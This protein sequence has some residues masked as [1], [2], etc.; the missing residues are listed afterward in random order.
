MS[1][2]GPKHKSP[3]DV[4]TPR[5]SEVNPVMYIN[6]P[7]L[8]ASLLRAMRTGY[9]VVIYGDSGC[10]KSWLYKKVFSDNRVYW[11]TL[12]FSASENADDVD[13]QIL[14]LVASFQEWQEE[15]TQTET[16]TRFAPGGVGAGSKRRKVM[17]KVSTSPLSQLLHHIR[18][19]AGRK[20]AFLVLENI[21]HVLDKPEVLR[22]IQNMLL[23]LDDPAIASHSVRLCLVG[24][25]AE[26][27]EVLTA[28]NKYQT[29]S[30]RVAEI[31]EVSRLPSE[32]VGLLVQRGLEQELDFTIE[33]RVYCISQIAFI[34]DRVP[35]YVHDICLH[36]ALLAEDNALTVT[37]RIIK[38]A[39]EHWVE[40]NARQAYEFIHECLVGS[41]PMS[42]AVARVVYSIACCDQRRFQAQEIEGL[43]RENF[44]RS[45]NG[46][47]VQVLK[48][49]RKLS[50]GDSR[51]LKTDDAKHNFRLL[52]PKLKPVLRASLKVENEEVSISHL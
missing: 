27:K 43:V 41:G 38:S 16:D 28:G 4:F 51:L 15:E 50:D 37:P 36:T 14:E 12:D 48:A 39:F 25:P 42:Q 7:E 26:I 45:T 20:R 23:A 44:P 30:N 22:Q 32:A 5:S 1:I 2:F 33:A 17:R 34:S 40:T 6:R 24:V 10:G 35:Q 31:P 8:E 49:L 11:S 47:R 29:I 46:K 52:T 13:L 18:R 21:E 3:E 9:H 19:V